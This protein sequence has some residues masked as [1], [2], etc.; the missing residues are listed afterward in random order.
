M[1]LWTGISFG[2]TYTLP[3][4]EAEKAVSREY[5]SRGI[6]FLCS[7]D[8]KGRGTGQEGMCS[9]AFWI[10]R[11]FRDSGLL[12]LGGSFYQTFFV[13]GNICRNIVGMIPAQGKSATAKNKYILITAHYDNLGILGERFYPGADSNASGV[14]AMLS[15]SRMFAF[16]RDSEAIIDQNIIFVALDAKQLSM[17]GAEDLWSRVTLGRLHNPTNGKAIGAKDISMMVNLDILGGTSAPLTEGRG[18]YLM[19]LGAERFGNVLKSVNIHNGINLE[20]GLDYYGSKNFTDMF[21][22]RVSDQKVFRSHGVFGVMFTSG[23]TM[24]TNRT[25]DTPEKI[26]T[27]VLQKRIKLIFHWVERMMFLHK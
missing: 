25:S 8:C 1:T 5:L 21:L 27:D 11:Q 13:R 7:D 15:L 10:G 12:P 9:A 17:A 18:D 24:D 20:I 23:I 16:L 19:L 3:D 22:N 26:D 4:M 6:E 14:M 2:Q